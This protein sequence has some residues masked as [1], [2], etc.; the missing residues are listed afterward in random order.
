[1]ELHV[2]KDV[3]KLFLMRERRGGGWGGEKVTVGL[4]GRPGGSASSLLTMALTL[5]LEILPFYFFLL[6][7]SVW[8]LHRPPRLLSQDSVGP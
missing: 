1:M 5:G 8:R 6:L 4:R 3:S 2:P 7:F